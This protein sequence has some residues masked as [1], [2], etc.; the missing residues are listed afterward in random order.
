MNVVFADTSY[1]LALT[2]PNDDS[3]ER[4]REYTAGFAG[5][6]LTTA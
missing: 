6:F 5:Q 1:Y 4:A 3:H 2:N